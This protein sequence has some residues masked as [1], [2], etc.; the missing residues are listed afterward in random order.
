M[1]EVDLLTCGNVCCNAG[2]WDRQL[3]EVHL[4]VVAHAKAVEE[5]EN[6]VA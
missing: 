2:K 1:A 4:F 6:I 3:V 5:I